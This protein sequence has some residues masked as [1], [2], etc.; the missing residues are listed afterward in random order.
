MV[1]GTLVLPVERTVLY[2]RLSRERATM[3]LYLLASGYMLLYV[4]VELP[5][6]RGR[7]GIR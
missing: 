6:K 1:L 5:L 2:S 4:N 7:Y 3:K